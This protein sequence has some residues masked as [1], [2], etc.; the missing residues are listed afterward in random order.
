MLRLPASNGAYYRLSLHKHGMASCPPAQKAVGA[1]PASMSQTSAPLIALVAVAVARSS[2]ASL[3][4]NGW[5][6]SPH[7]FP[8]S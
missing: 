3:A 1:S 2:R 8:A 5:G 4:N 6:P 7:G